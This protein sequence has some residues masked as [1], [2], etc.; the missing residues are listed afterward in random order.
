M[1][2]EW[3]NQ[4]EGVIR[5]QQLGYGLYQ[6]Q[7]QKLM[8]TPELRQAITILQYPAVELAEYLYNQMLENPVLDMKE[9]E[10]ERFEY[11]Y[12]NARTTSRQ[13]AS[14][15][16]DWSVWDTIAA[17]DKTLE[18]YLLEQVR[19]LKPSKEEYAILRFIIGNINDDGYF[20]LTVEEVASFF[21]IGNEKVEELL[22][23][24]HTLDPVGVGARNLQEALL[25]Q[26]E[27]MDPKD[28]L[29][30]QLVKNHLQDLGE[31]KVAKIAK[32]LSI[33]MQ[34]VQQLADFIKTLKPKPAM[35]FNSVNPRYIAAD[36]TI[37]KVDGEWI[38]M[39]NDAIVPRLQLSAQYFHY[40]QNHKE[41]PDD[42][43]K[44]IV[45][46][47]NQASWLIKSIEQRRLTLLKVTRAIIEHQE[48]FFEN[49]KLKP[50]TLKEIAQKIDVHESTVSRATNQKYLQTPVGVFE[51]KYFFTTGL[52]NQ[53]GEATA[54][55]N[56]KQKIK[57]LIEQEKKNKPFSDQKIA[58]ILIEGGIEISRRTVAKYRDELGIESSAK[59]KRFD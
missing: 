13:I 45:D 11:L 47:W 54:T 2:L 19:L 16:E 33:T 37:E 46:K 59:R 24:L 43:T 10:M 3:K 7:T 44:Y 52:V 31:W 4:Y 36:V 39:V 50:L 34:E 21:K 41:K 25:I 12:N 28:E 56:I 51:F 1:I 14:D 35:G 6:E 42:T 26:L 30:I 29:A 9:K 20:T 8:M 22:K 32:E 17:P 49:G 38:I 53:Q 48:D 5:M 57:E 40:V 15:D 55:E 18:E 58:D 23:F 27:Q